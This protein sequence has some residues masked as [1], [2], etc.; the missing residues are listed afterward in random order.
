MRNVDLFDEYLSG[1]MNSEDA[2]AFELK[3]KHD[4]NFANEYKDYLAIVETLQQAAFK[5]NL[6]AKLKKLHQEN[7]GKTN[8]VGIHEQKNFYSRFIKPFGVAASVAVF[9]VLAT[10]FLL[11]AGGYLIKKQNSDYTELK[12]ELYQLKNNQDAI[13]KHLS[14]A[15]TKS[16]QPANFSGTGFALN[17]KGYLITSLHMVN[18][19]DSV[20]I[21]LKSGEN[22]PARIVYTD[23]RLDIAILKLENDSVLKG[24][25]IPYSFKSTESDLGEKIFTL[26]YPSDFIVYG[27]GSVSSAAGSGDT[28]QYQISIPV[29]PGNSGGPLFDE[30]GNVIGVIRGKN[31][32]AEGTG[33]AIKS[34][35]IHSLIN[36]IEDET[37][38]SDL[39][40]PLK[41]NIRKQKR[42][43]QI[44]NVEPYIFTILVYKNN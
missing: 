13:R 15:K 35:Y 33:Y 30:E 2:N 34:V 27:E 42:N 39:K 11:S 8:I 36:S 16:K 41:N 18:A 7:F 9:A 32:N 20:Y 12:R 19:S 44:K 1:K 29:N 4:E 38:K 37:L 26:G 25:S 24:A 22:I 5:N 21:G 10:L 40:L 3:L 28:A 23:T 6:R 14:G 31:A 17:N 43:N